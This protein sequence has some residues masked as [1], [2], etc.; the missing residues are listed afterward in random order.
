[1]LQKVD[2]VDIEVIKRE[3]T[4]NGYGII[5]DG[6]LK[7]YCKEAKDEYIRS[8]QACETSPPKKKFHYSDLKVKPHRKFAIGSTNGIGENY[9][10]LLQTTYFSKTD[11]NYP[12]LGIVFSYLISLRNRILGI[13]EDYGNSP[14]RDGFWNACRIHHYPRGG[15]FMVGHRDTHFPK[16]LEKS[17]HPFLQIMVL[18]SKR[19]TD[20]NNGGGF[21]I[22]RHGNKKYYEKDESSFGEIVYFDGSIIHGVEDIDG[23]QILDFSK[24]SGRAA[25]FVGLYEVL[26]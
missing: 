16:L 22:D 4:A 17:G 13:N 23:D 15:G 10:Q 20:F 1:M 25:G 9:A 8:M 14:E 26:S 11:P 24:T 2:A 19:G 18:L 3:L 12:N 6:I 7:S 21:I 5:S